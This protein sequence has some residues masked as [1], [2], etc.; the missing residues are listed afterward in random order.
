M[1]NIT[2]K[3]I[4]TAYKDAL[5]KVKPAYEG[6]MKKEKVQW[7]KPPGRALPPPYIPGGSPRGY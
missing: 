5:K 3:Q 2:I 4:Q 6:V 1:A 7:P